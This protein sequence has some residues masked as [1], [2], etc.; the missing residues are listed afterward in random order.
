MQRINSC[1]NN[2]N[3]N[4]P[5]EFPIEN[6]DNQEVYIDNYCI[7]TNNLCELKNKIIQDFLAIVNKLECGIQ[8]DLEFL[9]EEISLVYIYE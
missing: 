2:T 5:I 3:L 6:N 8:P 1:C 7:E 4:S 9:L